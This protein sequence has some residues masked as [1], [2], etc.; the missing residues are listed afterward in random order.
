MGMKIQIEKGVMTKIKMV[1]VYFIL[2]EGSN[3]KYVGSTERYKE[4]VQEHKRDLIKGIHSN[5]LLQEEFN[6]KKDIE[7]TKFVLIEE[8]IN[9]RELEEFILNEMDFSNYYNISKSINSGNTLHNHPHKEEILKVKSENSKKELNNNWQGGKTFTNCMSC[10]LEI[11]TSR[12]QEK[13]CKSCHFKERDISGENNPFYGK[14]HSEE[15]IK[16]IVNN[17]TPVTPQNAKNIIVNGVEYTS[18]EE[19]SKSLGIKA[20]TIRHR[21]LSNNIKYKEYNVVGEEKKIFY[22]EGENK[23]NNV[24]I[25][26]EGV[27]YRTYKQVAE[28]FNISVGAVV[29]RLKSDN[30]KNWYRIETNK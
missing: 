25:F 3:K 15:T 9:G 21:C 11:K 4:R 27:M 20:G 28:E 17:R 7:R 5:I 1:S 19:A 2:L 14:S 10:G 8:S 26:A 18:Y 13:K 6:K 22:K 16:K 29:G 24:S 12:G 23:K 30:F